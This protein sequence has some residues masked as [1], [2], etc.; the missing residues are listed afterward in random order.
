MSTTIYYFSGTGNS[1]AVAKEIAGILEGSTLVSIASKMEGKIIP[2]SEVVGIVC[3]CYNFGVPVIVKDFLL[4]LDLSGVKYAFGIV[5]MASIGSPALRF[6]DILLRENNKSGLNSGYCL[7]MPSN[8]PQ[9]TKTP[10]QD[11]INETLKDAKK[12][13]ARI[14]K[15]LKGH[16]EHPPSW[17]NFLSII[18]IGL[19]WFFEKG[20]IDGS[21]DTKFV[22]SDA[23]TSCGLC[24]SVCPV[25]NIEI[26]NGKPVYHHKCQLCM[27]CLQFCPVEAI[28]HT[29][30]AGTEGRGRYHHPDLTVNDMK[31][32]AK[33]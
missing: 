3:P 15:E 11:K 14:G 26:S 17:I 7:K 9:F 22:I 29:M 16:E 21:L 2:D 6:M 33:Q 24:V 5:T 4:R 25:K 8:F 31:L 19:Y 32:Q 12:E 20:C 1:L 10:N 13:I 30:L 18:R 28:N 23:C 27:A